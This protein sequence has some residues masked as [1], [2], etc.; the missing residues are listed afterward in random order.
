MSTPIQFTLSL[1]PW[2][3]D[4]SAKTGNLKPHKYYKMHRSSENTVK[5]VMEDNFTVFPSQI[6]Y[7]KLTSPFTTNI[8]IMVSSDLEITTRGENVMTTINF[9]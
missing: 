3:V 4:H 5:P 2:P 8:S 7:G 1:R 6:D 9:E